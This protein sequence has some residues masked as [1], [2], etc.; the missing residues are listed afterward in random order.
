VISCHFDLIQAS[1]GATYEAFIDKGE[2]KTALVLGAG[3]TKKENCLAC[4]DRPKELKEAENKKLMHEKHVTVK[5]ARCFDCH[6]PIKHTKADFSKPLSE[7][8]GFLREA[9]SACHPEPH[10]LQQLLATGPKR[11]GVL[12]SPDPMHKARTNCLGCHV[13][14]KYTKKGQRV[15]M[16]SG[17]TCVRCHTKDHDK[18]LKDWKTELAKEI[19]DAK[20]LQK[21][22]EAALAKHKATLTPDK[23]AE[24]KQMLKQ[25]REDFRI[26]LFGNGVHNKKYSMMLLDAALTNFE[27]VIDELEEGG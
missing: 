10:R 6:Q 16:A 4:H 11:E 20:E 18:M 17:K 14:M 21:E 25:G 19:E 1:G 3:R 8:D 9:C 22:A 23:L 15:M 24:Y 12:A 26:V 27:D 7:Q 5:T 2:L 13:E